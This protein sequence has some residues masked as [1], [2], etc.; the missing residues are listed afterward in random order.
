MRRFFAI[1]VVFVVSVL[2][3]DLPAASRRAHRTSIRSAAATADARRAKLLTRHCFNGCPK[4]RRAFVKE[5][6]PVRL[7]ARDGYVLEHSAAEKIPVW[8]AEYITP[9]Q[10]NGDAKR[11]GFA[12]DPEL[13]E[14]ERSELEDYEGSDWDRGHQAPAADY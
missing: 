6:G 7:L 10:L 14:N 13:P 5:R 1:T 2:S 8:V 11:S 12:P 3:A 9:G 4:L